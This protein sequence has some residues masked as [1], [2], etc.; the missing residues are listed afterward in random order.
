MNFEQFAEMHGLIIRR[1]ML[2]KWVR[3]PTLDHPK[4]MNGAYIFEKMSEPQTKLSA[5]VTSGEAPGP[6]PP[7]QFRSCQ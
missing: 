4:K 5:F 7:S 1:L 2:D 3:V 6:V